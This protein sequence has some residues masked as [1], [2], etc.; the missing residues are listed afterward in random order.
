MDELPDSCLL[1]LPNID[2]DDVGSYKAVF[3]GRLLDNLKIKVALKK[4]TDIGIATTTNACTC[5]P[6]P[7]D[8][9]V[10]NATTTRRKRQ[11]AP[12]AVVKPAATVV[13]CVC[14]NAAAVDKAPDAAAA[15]VVNN[16]TG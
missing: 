5:T 1:T 15:A 8:P 11:A 2:E 16:T 9:P 14:P 7:A 6:A 12:D 13:N 10:A 4:A 3:P